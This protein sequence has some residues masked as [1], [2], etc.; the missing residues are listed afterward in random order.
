MKCEL[1]SDNHP[2]D[3]LDKHPS[4]PGEF[5]EPCVALLTACEKEAIKYRPQL[6]SGLNK[7]ECHACR[8]TK[9]WTEFGGIHWC[10]DC[11]LRAAIAVRKKNMP[12]KAGGDTLKPAPDRE[13]AMYLSREQ[14][15]AYVA[16]WLAH[17]A[18]QPHAQPRHYMRLKAL[19]RPSE[20]ERK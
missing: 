19:P 16:R 10:K 4:R 9:H 6:S 7:M 15:V 11:L 13:T 14:C 12:A 8:H 2:L 3:R 18:A 17:V 5:C 20:G 1:C